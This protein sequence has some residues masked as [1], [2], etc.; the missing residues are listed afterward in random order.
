MDLLSGFYMNLALFSLLLPPLRYL[1]RS[2][3]LGFMDGQFLSFHE[4][5][6]F[7]SAILISISQIKKDFAIRRVAMLKGL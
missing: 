6:F 7:L 3:D 1:N 2:A 4:G 5:I